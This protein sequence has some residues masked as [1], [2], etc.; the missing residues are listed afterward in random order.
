MMTEKS[1]DDNESQPLEQ[2]FSKTK[3][4]DQRGKTY[5]R[6]MGGTAKR[7]NRL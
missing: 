1:K 7:K 2:Y 3:R 4:R 6:R 5:E